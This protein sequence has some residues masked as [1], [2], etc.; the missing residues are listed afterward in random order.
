MYHWLRTG[1]SRLQ[2]CSSR[3]DDVSCAYFRSFCEFA[4][5][6]MYYSHLKGWRIISD[7]PTFAA[8]FIIVFFTSKKTT[9][10]MSKIGLLLMFV[11]SDATKMLLLLFMWTLCFTLWSMNV[12]AVPVGWS[13]A[14]AIPV[15]WMSHWSRTWASCAGVAGR[16][17][18]A[19]VWAM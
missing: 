2:C 17:C 5:M 16:V 12:C 4:H 14:A 13:M 7:R 1:L 15:T 9:K 10:F 3:L 19:Y 8:W 18:A 6:K 11:F